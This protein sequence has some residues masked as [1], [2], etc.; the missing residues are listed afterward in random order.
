MFSQSKA[1]GM[2]LGWG[3]GCSK[4][5]VLQIFFYHTYISKRYNFV[6]QFIR[7]F[8]Y[9]LSY[10]YILALLLYIDLYVV[11]FKLLDIFGWQNIGGQSP[12]VP[13]AM[14]SNCTCSRKNYIC[15]YLC[16][17]CTA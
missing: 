11:I 15:E 6:H 16:C 2:F 13:T 14:Q 4:N 9:P 7:D 17:K 8:Q 5:F 3:E 10:E 12:I 1:V